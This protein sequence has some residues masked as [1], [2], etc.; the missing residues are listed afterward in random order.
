MRKEINLIEPPKQELDE[1]ENET[2]EVNSGMKYYNR[3][4]KISN[5]ISKA[6]KKM[7]SN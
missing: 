5:I 7:E 2:L 4:M 1:Y 3:I 6:I